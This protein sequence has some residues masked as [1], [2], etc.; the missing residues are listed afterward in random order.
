MS[1]RRT[2]HADTC[3]AENAHE[4]NQVL[5]Q[6]VTRPI[7]EQLI[8]T[9]IK[10]HTKAPHY[11]PFEGSPQLT[12]CFLHD[13]PLMRNGFPCKDVIICFSYLE[14]PSGK[15]DSFMTPDNAVVIEELDFNFHHNIA[16]IAMGRWCCSHSFPCKST[17]LPYQAHIVIASHKDYWWNLSSM[18]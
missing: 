13:R 6:L 8:Q 5:V 16:Y 18:P 3:W 9:N 10:E 11:W 15:Y 17:I 2:F 7:V 12:G 1:K 14:C 4:Q